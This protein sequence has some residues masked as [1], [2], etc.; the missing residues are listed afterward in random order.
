VLSAL[1]FGECDFARPITDHGMGAGH[2]DGDRVADFV[3]GLEA[4]DLPHSLGI[5]TPPAHGPNVGDHEA[6]SYTLAY[7]SRSTLSTPELSR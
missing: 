4:A 3:Q 5:G 1:A 7:P 6:T 2:V